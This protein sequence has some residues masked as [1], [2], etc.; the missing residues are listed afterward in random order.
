MTQRP[1]HHPSPARIW[2]LVAV[3]TVIAVGAFGV[4][5]T[6]HA[7]SALGWTAF[8][9]IEEALLASLATIACLGRVRRE[10]ATA[11]RAAGADRRAWKAWLA[12]AIGVTAWTWGQ[13]GW[14]VWEVGLNNTVPS[15]SILDAAFLTF[16]VLLV[17]GLLLMV[18]TPAGPLSQL[19]GA[20]EGLLIASGFFLLG[21]TI[22]IGSVVEHSSASALSQGVNLAY[23][24][25]DTVA[26]AALFYMAL[27]R[28]EDPPPGLALLA[29]GI[30]CIAFSDIS[31]WYLNAVHLRFPGISG[32]DTG[33][34][35]GFALIALA[36]AH[37][38]EEH[39]AEAPAESGR[40]VA[41]LLGRP[42]QAV[43][44]GHERRYSRWRELAAG[45]SILLVPALPAALGVLMVPARWLVG[46]SLGPL[47]VLVAIL[48]AVAIFGVITQVIVAY[49][50]RALTDHLEQRVQERTAEIY[51][52]ER[53]YR[54]VVEHSSDAVMVVD[55]DLGIRD[56]SES[57]REIFGFPSEK[58]VGSGLE[59]FGVN[60]ARVLTEAL[61]RSG[62]APGQM[63]R[64][65]WELTDASGR[66]RHAETTIT[67]LLADPHVGAFVLN[68]RDDTERV[69][70]VDQLRRQTF[71]DP[72]TGLY[73]RALLSDRA[74]HA[75]ARSLRSGAR[76]AMVILDLD[77]FKWINESLGHRAGDGLLIEVAQRLK[78]T[79]R[80]EDTVARFGG[81]EF[82]VLMDAVEGP[83]DA[84]VVAER[85]RAAL[86][87]PFDLLA[88]SGH[89][90][91]ASIG[92]AVG[93]ASE[94]TFEE[95]LSHADMAMHAV[96]AGGKNAVQLFEP[97]MHKK[98]REHFHLQGD[99]RKALDN[100]EFWLLYQ[101]IFDIQSGRESLEGF[102]A[103]IR[104]NHPTR[105]LIRPDHFISLAEETGL[106]VPVGQWVLEAALAQAS[107]WAG[108][109][110]A[111]GAP[112]PPSPA[113]VPLGI[114]VNVSAV[115]LR[116]PGLL[117]AVEAAL[118]SARVDPWHVILEITET[119][120]A[121]DSNRMLDVLHAL[122]EL[123][124]RIAIDD[125]GTGY[126]S[127]AYLRTMPVDILKIDRAFIASS[128]DGERGRE[129]LEAIVSMGRT[130]SLVMV[131][132]GIETPEQL[133]LMRA[134]GCDLA[135]GYLLGRPMPADETQHLIAAD[136]ITSVTG[137]DSHTALESTG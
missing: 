77:A 15:P 122:K 76:V 132:E 86:L 134:L 60:A 129:L 12:I 23:P 57:M 37:P 121:E 52:T 59:V 30:I 6:L 97:S 24:A 54:A 130:L 43:S 71:H 61:E 83:D 70:L 101:P 104:W 44:L 123:G 7:G 126:S 66:T 17:V 19:R 11:A 81:D 21:W 20:A 99:L 96:K 63:V 137:A 48:C 32:L 9:D 50:N 117:T 110:E 14:T 131:A 92:V 10:R 95:L 22:I 55:P 112:A 51:A 41:R 74:A 111:P 73:H 89:R 25:F 40:S 13:V 98:A 85:M 18:Q 136:A 113:A 1:S 65:G 119:S 3:F 116:A 35:A 75:F 87:E 88:E 103:L 34:V 49:E 102:E 56:V 133:E 46:E 45:R 80:P 109:R 84:L 58:L 47:G 108:T 82:L 90:V 94:T 115:Q 31:F 36:A 28:R 135:Q 107:T 106:I 16:P 124:V 114:S 72:L 128:G 93:S 120:L 5:S 29:L 91:T 27:R 118:E 62:L 78:Q 69:K 42:A 79:T 4:L 67:N 105:G 33:W 38:A 8:D 53:Y 100:D 68:T 64:T 26:L 127:L 125:F 39:L 2:S